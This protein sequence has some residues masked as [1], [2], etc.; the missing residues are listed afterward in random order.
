M[1][2]ARRT[3]RTRHENDAL[4]HLR[5]IVA[6]LSASARSLEKRTG[7]TNAQ[8]FVLQSLAAAPGPLT[9]GELRRTVQS[10]QSAVSLIVARLERAGLVTRGTAAHDRRRRAVA[11]TAKGARIARRGPTPPL[12]RVMDGL[13][14]LRESELRQLA[15][16]LEA[17]ATAIGAASDDPPPMFEG[18]AR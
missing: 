4:R 18:P 16:G 9:I 2:A 7:V 13:A 10:G 1:A 14:D 17:L 11:L 6:E 8:L 12:A 3:A 15:V 5:A